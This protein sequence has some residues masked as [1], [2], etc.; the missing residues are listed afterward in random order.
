VKRDHGAIETSIVLWEKSLARVYNPALPPYIQKQIDAVFGGPRADETRQ[1]RTVEGGVSRLDAQTRRGALAALGNQPL[2]PIDQA[3]FDRVGASL[4]DFLSATTRSFMD[5]EALYAGVE[6]LRHIAGDKHLIFV[7][8]YGISLPSLDDDRALARVAADARVSLNL[9]HSGGMPYN[10]SGAIFAPAPNM[11]VTGQTGRSLAQATGGRFLAHRS[12]DA[13]A[14]V[15]LIEGATRFGYV[16]GY[17][18][19]KG[20]LDG[21]FRNVRVSVNRPGLTVLVRSGYF[22]RPEVTPIER[23]GLQ[24]YGRVVSAAGHP[25]N[26]PD[27]QIT[28]R[29]A[30]MQ[31]ARGG[32][33]VAAEMTIDLSRVVFRKEAGRNVGSVDLAVF[34]VTS[35]RVQRTVGQWWNTLAF[36]FTDDRL[37]AVR[38]T[39][40]TQRVLVPVTG[41]PK[42][43]KIIVYDYE[44]DLTGSAVIKVTGR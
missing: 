25:V 24:I 17:Y 33:Q 22:A 20:A 44:S 23:R 32:G 28:P 43:L 36:T 29:S 11:I 7:S 37:A 15:D 14:D 9:I 40:L 38:A 18:P 27:I 42:E 2:D 19:S 41:T 8:E 16:L 39:G 3:E 35:E 12:R 4:D 6:Y 34:A 31:P 30:L 26:V 13:L 1:T 21:K 10:V 5:L